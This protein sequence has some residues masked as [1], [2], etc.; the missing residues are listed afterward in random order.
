MKE[1]RAYQRVGGISRVREGLG[2]TFFVL[3]S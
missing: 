1:T 2:K 3:G